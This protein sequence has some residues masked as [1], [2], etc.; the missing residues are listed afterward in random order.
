MLDS[1]RR[2]RNAR[3]GE[4]GYLKCDTSFLN[5]FAIKNRRVCIRPKVS[6]TVLGTTSL[7]V[8]RM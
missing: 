8:D 5:D 1:E 6:R 3:L 7:I 4:L 2:L